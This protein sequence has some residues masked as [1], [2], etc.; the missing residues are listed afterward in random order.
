MPRPGN[1]CIRSGASLRLPLRAAVPSAPPPPR[2]VR[3]SLEPLPLNK[4]LRNEETFFRVPQELDA[5]LHCP[6][7]HNFQRQI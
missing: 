6:L 5:L 2:A 7:I 4:S 1:D 3:I